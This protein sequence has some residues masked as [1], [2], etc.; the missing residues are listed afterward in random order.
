MLKNISKF[1]F[2]FLKA[3][4]Y[5]RNLIKPYGIIYNSGDLYLKKTYLYSNKIKFF[6]TLFQKEIILK[7]LKNNNYDDN[8][9]E[10]KLDNSN[11]EK[12]HN[13]KK[14][15]FHINKIKKISDIFNDK[16]QINIENKLEI[17]SENFIKRDIEKKT[18]IDIESESGSES[19]FKSEISVPK[20]VTESVSVSEVESESESLSVSNEI[21]IKTKFDY[22]KI[23]KTFNNKIQENLEQKDIINEQFIENYDNNNDEN[24]SISLDIDIN[25]NIIDFQL[26]KEELLKKFSEISYYNSLIKSFLNPYFIS[27]SAGRY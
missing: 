16:T 2:S 18:Y 7:E 17:Q 4:S 24:I 5:K 25:K 20:I 15:I 26:I 12:H 21:K 22:K 11:E 23:K 10:E 27:K 1:N 13:K 3:N 14:R 8:T 9:I 6:T 19:E